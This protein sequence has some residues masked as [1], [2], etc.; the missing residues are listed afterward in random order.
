[1]IQNTREFW[2]GK[3]LELPV[4]VGYR[5]V[6]MLYFDVEVWCSGFYVYMLI[7]LVFDMP[8]KTGLKLIAP[9]GSDRACL[10]QFVES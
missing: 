2:A 5:N 7:S 6:R 9:I 8:V 10:L 4:L 3:A 1:L